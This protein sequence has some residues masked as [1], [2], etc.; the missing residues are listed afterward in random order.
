[1]LRHP[2]QARAVGSD[3]N[4]VTDGQPADK[5]GGVGEF[6]ESRLDRRECPHG[7]GTYGRPTVLIHLEVEMN[8]NMARPFLMRFGLP[9]DHH[10][11]MHHARMF[12]RT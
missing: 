6:D 11:R 5:P 1:M 9:V 4:D 8:A 12:G 2:Q 10:H 3:P 7:F